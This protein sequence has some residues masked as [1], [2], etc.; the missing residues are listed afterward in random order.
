NRGG[1]ISDCVAIVW[2]Y[3]SKGACSRVGR[4]RGIFPWSG[5]PSSRRRDAPRAGVGTPSEAWPRH[6]LNR[7][8][9]ALRA[10]TV[11]AAGETET[12]SESRGPL[13]LLDVGMRY[14]DERRER[15]PRS[16]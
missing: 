3:A 14:D 13:R 6:P 7:G 16:T 12:F 4:E 11:V 1:L 15:K 8:R 2:G 10:G 5:C 9:D